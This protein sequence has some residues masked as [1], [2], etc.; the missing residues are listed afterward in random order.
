MILYTYERVNVWMNRC[1]TNNSIINWMGVFPIELRWMN[2]RMDV[3]STEWVGDGCR[4]LNEWKWYQF[5]YRLNGWIINWIDMNEWMNERIA[6]WI[7]Y[8]IE[9]YQVRTNVSLI[10]WVYYQFDNWL[11]G[12]IN[13]L[14][15]ELSF[16]L[17]DTIY[18]WM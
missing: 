2:G 15:V 6:N 5:N 12:R 18:V 4:Q 16:Q 14:P 10:E 7:V 3:L 8:S 9:W 11:N 17:N 13:V 1:D